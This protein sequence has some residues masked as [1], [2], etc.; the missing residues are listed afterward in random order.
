VPAEL[1]GTLYR[2]GPGRIRLGAYKYEHWFDGDG[3]LTAIELDG[4]K[5]AVKVLR[6]IRGDGAMEGAKGERW[7]R[8]GE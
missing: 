5:N 7:W 8:R 6:S 3:Y 1:T 4:E 2:A